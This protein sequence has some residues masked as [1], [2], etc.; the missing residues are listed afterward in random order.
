[1]QKIKRSQQPLSCKHPI[2]PALSN[3]LSQF[4]QLSNYSSWQNIDQQQDGKMK[5]SFMSD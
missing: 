3:A 1:M 4:K 2:Y 5:T